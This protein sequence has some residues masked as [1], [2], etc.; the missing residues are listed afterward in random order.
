RAACRTVRARGAARIVLAVPVAPPDW[1]ARLAGEADELISLETPAAFFAVGQFYDDFTQL[2]DDDVVAC[3]RRA[4]SGGSRTAV[5]REM[6]AAVGPVR[7]TG[8][9]T[10]PADAAGI[11]VFAHGSG[12]GRHSPRNRFVAVGLNRAGLGT[13]LCDLLTEEEAAD[14]TK[15]FD[16]GL[17][18]A[19]LTAVTA[20]LRADPEAGNLPVGY[21]GASTGAAAALRA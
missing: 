11:V 10:V 20:R 21:F 19:R 12:S 14:R 2:D 16:I 3:L 9:L 1:T 4:R 6:A 17:L 18:A 13:L 5:D 15:V 7:L 8:R